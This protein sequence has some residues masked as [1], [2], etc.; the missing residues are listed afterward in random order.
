M[1][2]WNFIPCVLRNRTVISTA[3]VYDNIITLI[4]IQILLCEDFLAM[5]IGITGISVLHLISI[6]LNVSMIE[7]MWWIPN[8]YLLSVWWWTDELMWIQNACLLRHQRCNLHL[9]MCG[10]L[11]ASE[12]CCSLLSSSASSPTL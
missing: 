3:L 10:Y 1:F 5:W 11:L 4:D 6:H 8:V 7:Y 2:D 12:F 9:P